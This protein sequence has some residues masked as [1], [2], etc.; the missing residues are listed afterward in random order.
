MG[1]TLKSIGQNKSGVKAGLNYTNNVTVGESSEKK[2]NLLS[3]HGGVFSKI[4]LNEKFSLN[5][6]L[7][8]SRK[9][10]KTKPNKNANPSSEGKIYFNY[11]NL[12]ILIGYKVYKKIELQTGA[13]LGYLLSAKAKYETKTIDISQ[14]WDNKIDL[15]IAIGLE[16]P[17]NEFISI[18]GRYVHGL[19]SVIKSPITTIDENH[20]EI[21]K[22]IKFQNRTFQISIKIIQ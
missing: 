7:L 10:Y 11:I 17:I 6:E 15:G 5:T 20:N 13:E 18:N 12:P 19:T 8:F 16:F 14:F 1:I 9:G 3:F 2:Q 4:E 21:K 22:D